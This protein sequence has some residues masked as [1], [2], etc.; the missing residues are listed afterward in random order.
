[1]MEVRLTRMTM[2][3]YSVFCTVVLESRLWS[4]E[5]ERELG[6]EGER[7]EGWG[8]RTINHSLI[9]KWSQR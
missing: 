7:R 8:E 4:R 6:K 2:F 5:G 9:Q 1:M 3:M